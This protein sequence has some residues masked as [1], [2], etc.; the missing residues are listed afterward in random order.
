MFIEAAINGIHICML[1]DTG[2]T[3]SVVSKNIYDKV[4]NKDSSERVEKQ[5][6]SANSKPLNA[7]GKLRIPISIDD[8]VYN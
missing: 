5:V 3:L 6:L 2:N 7:F 1:V 4:M 8:I